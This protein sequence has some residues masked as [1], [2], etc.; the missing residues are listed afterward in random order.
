[1]ATWRP[2]FE[3]YD[4]VHT[5]NTVPYTQSPWVMTF[6][7]KIPGDLQTIGQ[8]LKNRLHLDNC[9]KLIALSDYA[10]L[11]LERAGQDWPSIDKILAKVEVVHP[12][13][14]ARAQAPKRFS[15]SRPLT[16]VFIG[17][18]FAR[19]GGIVALRVANKAQQRG[20]P[21]QVHL[22]S[23][24]PIQLSSTDHLDR[25]RYAADLEQ[26]GL[27]NV[28]FHGT[29]TN[30]A[31]LDLLQ[32][33]DFQ[34]LATLHDSYGFSVVEGFS[35][36]TPAITTNI[37][38]LPELVYPDRNGHLLTLDRDESRQWKQWQHG[39]QRYS[40]DYWDTLDKTYDSLANQT[41]DYLESFYDR[42]DR[43]DY[44]EQLSQGALDQFCN[45]NHAQPIGERLDRI[46]AEAIA[47]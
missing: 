20:L 23:E 16:L 37:C 35:L 8:L 31:V 36:A 3:P 41:I 43:L 40:A 26:L 28:T 12:N 29:L 42:P 11:K 46:Y 4:L 25:D 33:S 2:A 30:Q 22:V 47:G 1:M 10:R 15:D 18:H 34:L 19:K 5:F 24:M 6:E 27:P 32:R 45:L 9:K 44:Y 13:F 14:P 7:Q 38:A 21:L 17:R 39:E